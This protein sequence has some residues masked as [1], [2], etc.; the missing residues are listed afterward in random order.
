MNICFIQIFCKHSS[1]ETSLKL[2]CDK[3]TP[4]SFYFQTPLMNLKKTNSVKID[5]EFRL[6][7]SNEIIKMK[8]LSLDLVFIIFVP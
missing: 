5:S 8:D 6:N 3:D 4:N 1:Q 2:F 7:I